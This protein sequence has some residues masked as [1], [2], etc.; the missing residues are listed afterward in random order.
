MQEDSI[1]YVG[2][3][4]GEKYDNI[5]CSPYRVQWEVDRKCHLASA[6]SFDKLCMHLKEDKGFSADI[7]AHGSRKVVDPE[8]VSKNMYHLPTLREAAK[9]F[10]TAYIELD[11]GLDGELDGH[12]EQ[13][14]EG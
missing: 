5:V 10:I 1:F 11:G 4:T 13:N 2:S 3:T 12:T 8:Y 6:Q 9:A 14:S 7:S